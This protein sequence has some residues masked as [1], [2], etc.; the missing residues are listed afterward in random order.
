M[1]HDEHGWELTLPVDDSRDPD[2]LRRSLVALVAAARDDGGGTVRWIVSGPDDATDAAASAHGLGERRDLYQMRRPLPVERSEPGWVEPPP[3]RAFRPGTA[4]ED[5]WI[6]TNNRAF[7]A[8]PD[9]SSFTAERLHARMEEAWFD[10]DGF[11]LHERAGKLAAFCWTKIHRDHEPQLGEIY[12][13]GV[14]P[15]FQGLGLGRG[16][17]LAGLDWL[18]GRGI[19]VGMLYV[20]AAN[21]A[22]VSLYRSLGFT[23]HHTDRVYSG[24]VTRQG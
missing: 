11:R 13:I 4:D 18:A 2:V 9:Q 19:G 3:T 14:D 23:E 6:A 1:R 15:E 12:V 16:L 21:T 5:A 10:A 20:A 8:D 22:A 24:G 7:A 17:T